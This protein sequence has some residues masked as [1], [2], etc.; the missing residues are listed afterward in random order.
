MA[1]RP[2]SAEIKVVLRLDTLSTSVPPSEA[3]MLRY[4]E[5]TNALEFERVLDFPGGHSKF[6]IR[7]PTSLHYSGHVLSV[8]T[9][10]S[11]QKTFVLY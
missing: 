1:Y 8:R 11:Q 6:T 4:D 5:P 7:Y 9:M 3:I 2:T 10:I